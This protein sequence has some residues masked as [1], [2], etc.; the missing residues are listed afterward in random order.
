MKIM[1]QMKLLGQSDLPRSCTMYL[2]TS[3]NMF[4]EIFQL[5][6]CRNVHFADIHSKNCQPLLPNKIIIHVPMHALYG[7]LRW[8]GRRGGEGRPTMHA[9]CGLLRWQAEEEEKG[10]R[11]CSSGKRHWSLIM[12]WL[13]P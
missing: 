2:R 9:L 4:R 6:G 5:H 3:V 7:L 8:L 11:P 1:A 13:L 10:V 12:H